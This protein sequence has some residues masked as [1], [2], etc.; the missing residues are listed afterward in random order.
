[1]RIHLRTSPNIGILPF[2]YQQKLVGCIHKWIGAGNDEHGK[3]SL[4]SFSWLQ[5]GTRKG[6]GLDFP[7]GS[8]WFISFYKDSLLRQVLKSIMENP[9]MFSGMAITDVVIEETPD[10]SDRNIFYSGSPVFIQKHSLDMSNNVQYTFEDSESDDMLTGTL[11]HKMELAGLSED[12]TLKVSF[13][14]NYPSKKT[15]LITYKGINL[16]SSMCPVII[17]G[18]PETKAFAWNVGIGNSTGIGFG[19]IY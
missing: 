9:E 13:D 11:L 2:N 19:S 18:K 7:N 12:K 15:K 3:M 1:M 6:T 17:E 4:Y 8:K 16:R 5:N 10:L 14:R